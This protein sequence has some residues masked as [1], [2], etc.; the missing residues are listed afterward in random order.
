[1]T[2]FPQLVKE[3]DAPMAAAV[4]A[5]AQ[6]KPLNSQQCQ[7]WVA[8]LQALNGSE[9][10]ARMEQGKLFAHIQQTVEGRF[11]QF[12]RDYVK[13]TFGYG[14]TTVYDTLWAWELW[15][16]IECLDRFRWS[17]LVMLAKK[18][19]DKDRQHRI[20]VAGQ[21]CLN[22]AKHGR[23][24]TVKM[25]QDAL[26]EAGADTIHAPLGKGRLKK[27]ISRRRWNKVWTAAGIDPGRVK[28]IL[29]E[30]GVTVTLQ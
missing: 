2:F 8:K 12:I 20:K 27:G 17:A 30:L 5:P 26:V 14:R 13:P 24:I 9:N 11:D 6:P 16:G 1:M 25:A 23:F 28:A 19:T 21:A 3:V 4:K 15:Q 29:I 22:K 10:A 7:E 18:V